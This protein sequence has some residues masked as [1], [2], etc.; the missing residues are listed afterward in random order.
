MGPL[1]IDEKIP[2]APPDALDATGEELVPPD[3]IGIA[4]ATVGVATGPVLLSVPLDD[5]T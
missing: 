5:S 2:D 4:V 1:E 3:A